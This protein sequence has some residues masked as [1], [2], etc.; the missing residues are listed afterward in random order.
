[1]FSDKY[2]DIQILVSQHDYIKANVR[3]SPELVFNF[4]EVKAWDALQPSLRLLDKVCPEISNWT[5]LKYEQKKLIWIT[6]QH[7]PINGSYC[8]H[9][10]SL[11]LSCGIFDLKDGEKAC[12][13]AHEFRHSRQNFS[14]YCKSS[15]AFLITG[16]RDERIIEDDA[17]FY[18]FKVREAI[19][20]IKH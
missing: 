2:A 19:F 17:Y 8:I 14:K 13:L 11:M 5:R 3:T 12:T 4:N 20:G 18:E 9:N 6:N 1:M 10:D 7:L 16:T 15:I